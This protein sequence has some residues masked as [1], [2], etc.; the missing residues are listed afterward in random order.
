[1]LKKGSNRE[2]YILR[3]Y[4]LFKLHCF[5]FHHYNWE[6]LNIDEIPPELLFQVLVD[7]RK[8]LTLEFLRANTL[9]YP[10]NFGHDSPFQNILA[11]Y[12]GKTLISMKCS[13]NP[14][15]KNLDLLKFMRSSVETEQTECNLGTRELWFMKAILHILPFFNDAQ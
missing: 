12:S 10:V 14:F 7:L 1:M 15:V 6:F 8:D 11:A 9:K 2:F 4:K 13:T 3:A 5:H